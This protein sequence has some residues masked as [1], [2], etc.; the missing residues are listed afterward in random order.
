[1]HPREQ[2]MTN[3]VLSDRQQR[4]GCTGATCILRASLSP[5]GCVPPCPPTFPA[6]LSIHHRAP[7]KAGTGLARQPEVKHSQ[8]SHE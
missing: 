5:Q 6:S 4:E 1:M 8:K 7:S 2:I 3:Q